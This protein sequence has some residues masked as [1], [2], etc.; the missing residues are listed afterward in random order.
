MIFEFIATTTETVR[1][2][3]IYYT[4]TDMYCSR[5]HP[6]IGAKVSS[7]A[8]SGAQEH[9]IAKKYFQPCQDDSEDDLPFC[10]ID[11]TKEDSRDI[12]Q[13][14]LAHLS[15]ELSALLAELLLPNKINNNNNNNNN[16]KN[17]K[18]NNT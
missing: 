4:D 14:L 8:S 5:L 9:C 12:Q 3:V 16:N 10:K 11:V 7:G 15:I 2:Y 17:T 1:Y 18:K 6:S 13:L